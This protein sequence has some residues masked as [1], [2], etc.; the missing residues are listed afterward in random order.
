MLKMY[1]IGRSNIILEFRD[2]WEIDDLIYFTKISL[3]F[4]D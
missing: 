4:E 3:K 2:K 1:K